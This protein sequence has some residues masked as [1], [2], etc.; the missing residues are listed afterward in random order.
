[1]KNKDIIYNKLVELN[2][3]NGI[4]AQ[5]LASI[6]NMSR[7][8]VSHE[9]NKLVKEGK[10]C[11]SN[12]RPVLFYLNNHVIQKSKHSI[13][14]EIAKN[15]I[16]LTQA[17]EQIK[18][19]ILY[20][21]KGMHCLILGETGVGKSMFASLMHS[22]AVEMGVKPAQSP[23]ITFNCADYSNNPQLLTSHLFGV[24]KGA[25]TGAENDKPGLIE[26]A[27]GGILFLDEVHRL[28][29]EGQEA[30]FTFLDTGTYRR[31]GDY[32][33]R[34][35]EVLIISATTENPDS[36]LLKTFTRRIPMVIKIPSLRERT[37]EERLYLIKTFFKQESIRLGREIFVSLNTIR[38]LLSYECPNN[39]GQLKSDIQLL[40]A[41]AYSEFLTNLKR[42]I[43]INSNNLPTYIK[44]GL[45]KEK[46]HRILWNK[47]VGDEI[48]FFRFSSNT[49][50]QIPIF[51]N[52][53]SK[54]Y[55]MLEQKL[56][57]LKAK[58]ISNIDIEN[59]LEKDIYRYFEKYIDGITDDMNKKHLATIV[60]E[61]ILELV[62]NI[63][64]YINSKLNYKLNNNMYT[65]L[66]LHID[67]LIKRIYSEKPIINPQ[68]NKIK[69]LYPKEFEVALEIKNII[70][71][72][73]NQ[74]IP[75]DEAGYLTIFLIPEEKSLNNISDKVKVL[76]ICHGSGIA[77][78][79]AEVANKLL[80]VDYVIGIN[81]PLDVSPSE[82]LESVKKSI[83][84]N[85]SQSGY[86]LLVDMGSL[87]TFGPT[88]EK[89]FKIPVKVIPLVSTLHVIEATRKALLGLSLDEIYKDLISLNS[90]I[91]NSKKLNE[92]QQISKD[93]KIVIITACLTGEGS[94]IA[95][96]SFLYDHLK[97][98]KN[99]FEIIALNCLNE[100]AFIKQLE[101]INK[102]KEILFI[103]SSFPIKTDIKI[104]SIYDVLS[105]K[106]IDELQNLIDTKSTI[107][108]MGLILK[109]NID[110]LDGEI[111][112]NNIIETIK[113]IEKNL[114]LKLNDDR[115]IGLILH[116]AFTISRLKKGN[117][118]IE[119]PA[120]ND[121]INNHLYEYSIIKQFLYT[122]C[123]KY[124]IV[125]SD[126][127]VCYVVNF[128]LNN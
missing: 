60:G 57:K 42:D 63:S 46:Q 66:S 58:G 103:V 91:E 109:E 98:D 79:M 78:S 6:L 95:V 108:K 37:I 82:V 41:K 70:E 3:E 35:A 20:P 100:K 73:I 71:K 29:P 94:S 113:N 104:Y 86:L 45:Y 54:I 92:P 9:L 105:M 43:R 7:A 110:N 48:E 116:L 11:K 112:Y 51:S 49:D 53:D 38:A 84:N 72:F 2:N 99:R 15:N 55:N 107:L 90:F 47:L 96:K 67:T 102:E 120:K 16:S 128:F 22:Y 118:S 52:N 127:E 44:E 59:I 13:L 40:C 76:I 125:F 5:T 39:I 81:A 12:S 56:I 19:A 14:D 114:C 65:T 119:Y 8:N 80:N 33:I 17:I 69:Q 111:L 117:L 21:P 74:S 88:L 62:D 1:M 68:L 126:N 25:Y 61:E 50:N 28:P 24:K 85:Y 77:T 26:Q 31:I 83:L 64:D 124:E 122:L 121:F 75:E 123:N 18:A 27:N 115:L 97:F 10:I 106:V 32:E 87:T 30:L 34:H 23:F 36:A 89:E 93:K 4:D 101:I